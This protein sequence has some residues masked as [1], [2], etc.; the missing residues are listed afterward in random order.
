MS[1]VPQH[2]GDQ[3]LFLDAGFPFLLL[4][5]WWCEKE[6]DKPFKCFSHHREMFLDSLFFLKPQGL[7]N[8]IDIKTPY[9]S[10]IM[11]H[12]NISHTIWMKS[13]HQTTRLCSVTDGSQVERS[14]YS[15]VE[16]I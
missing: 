13:I 10:L 4:L 1:V 14:S 12:K 11:N 6:A 15:T 16:L 2:M 5:I 9:M 8:Y 7:Q 3:Q